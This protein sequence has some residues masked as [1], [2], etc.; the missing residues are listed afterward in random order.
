M[1]YQLYSTSAQWQLLWVQ[2]RTPKDTAEVLFWQ[3]ESGG[4]GKPNFSKPSEIWQSKLQ[5]RR[6]FFPSHSSRSLFTRC[7]LSLL[8]NTKPLTGDGRR[9]I[10]IWVMFWAIV[11]TNIPIDE[12]TLHLHSMSF[13]GSNIPASTA[14]IIVLYVC[15]LYNP[16]HHYD[17]QLLPSSVAVLKV[18]LG[19]FR[20]GKVGVSRHCSESIYL[21]LYGPQTAIHCHQPVKYNSQRE[22]GTQRS[23]WQWGCED[24]GW[25][26]CLK[27]PIWRVQHSEVTPVNSQVPGAHMKT[28]R[29]M[30]SRHF[31]QV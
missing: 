23:F 26:M 17:D 1:R 14:A 10:E 19:F 2:W 6:N 24:V 9:V 15:M 29:L 7:L 30:H 11:R 18:Q 27:C 4:S 3:C 22:M 16:P 12:L 31:S 21:H 8:N 5:K 28:R 25:I 13:I 20:C